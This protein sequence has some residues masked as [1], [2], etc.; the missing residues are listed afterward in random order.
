ME[1]ALLVKP[2]SGLIDFNKDSTFIT[3]HNK[4]RNK[5]LLFFWDRPGI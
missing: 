1:V 3:A 2:D 4:I 5:F